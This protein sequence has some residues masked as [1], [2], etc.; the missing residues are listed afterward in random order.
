MK[1]IPNCRLLYLLKIGIREHVD[2]VLS[3]PVQYIEVFEK[4]LWHDNELQDKDSLIR[5]F[6][7]LIELIPILEYYNENFI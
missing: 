4:V 7:K 5:K 1:S 6:Q 3:Y 2:L